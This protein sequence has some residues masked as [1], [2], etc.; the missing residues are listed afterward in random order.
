MD[1]SESG[2]AVEQ[3]VS[4]EALMD[5]LT[6]RDRRWGEMPREW[7]FR[8]HADSKWGLVPSAFRPLTFRY[9]PRSEFRP[10]RDHWQ[11]VHEEGVLVHRFLQALDKQGLTLPGESSI[12]WMD[13]NSLL[14]DLG[15]QRIRGEWPPVELAPLF[16]LAQHHGIP[17]RLLDWTEKPLVA[18]YFAAIGG[19]QRLSAGA[20]PD[21][22]F[23][24]W[25]LDYT[26]ARTILWKDLKERAQPDI[27][28]VR[29]PRFSNPNL[30]AQEGV[31]TVLVDPTRKDDDPAYYPQLD[32]L[33]ALR[34]EELRLAGR[35]A[36]PPVIR[37]FDVPNSQA[38]RLLRL[39]ADESVSG[40]YLYPGVDGVIR[41]LREHA[42]WDTE[43]AQL[44]ER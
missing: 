23:S 26:R 27:K 21:E 11:Q 16:A 41:G 2:I 28:M 8:G 7:I 22:S 29:A 10:G 31:F 19:A 42:F 6:R 25:A 4:A 32:E 17:T 38:G 9:G 14:N 24:V 13:F 5:A 12:R 37:K 36:V 30:R 3:I 33:I 15:S 1:T 18:A 20:A 44:P 40:T 43:V 34:F 39:L 35:P